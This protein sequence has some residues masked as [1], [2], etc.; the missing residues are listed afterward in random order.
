LI[1][2]IDLKTTDYLV[3]CY[4]VG[5]MMFE[6]SCMALVEKCDHFFDLRKM[7]TAPNK[8]TA[9]EALHS[10]FLKECAE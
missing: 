2:K 4:M 3:D 5:F 10:N 6:S 1:S 7:L 8:C 9:K